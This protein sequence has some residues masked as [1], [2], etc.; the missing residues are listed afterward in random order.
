MLGQRNLMPGSPAGWPDTSADWDGSSGLLKRVAWADV[1]AQRMGDARNARDLAPQLLGATLSDETAKAIGRAESGSQALTLLLASPEFMRRVTMNQHFS[2]RS[3]IGTSLFAGA[4]SLMASR[5]AFANAPTDARFVFVLLRGALDGLSAVP[6]VGDPEYAGLR[7]QIALA[8][9]GEGAAL[10][11]EGPF[12]LHPA[13][14]FFTRVMPRKSWRCCM[15]WPRLIA[16]VRISTRRTCSRA[17]SCARMDR[18][19]AGSIAR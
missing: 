6:P 2:R 16:N 14:K 10:P 12:G 13:L 7:G 4:S 19:V 9:T 15:P 18:R 1:V 5:L 17:A 8:K 11:L 3:F